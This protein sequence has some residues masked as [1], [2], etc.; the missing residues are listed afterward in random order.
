MRLDHLL[1]MEKHQFMVESFLKDSHGLNVDSLSFF[2][3][4]KYN[5]FLVR[6]RAISSVG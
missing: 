3:T 1:S 2:R 4:S 5:I 6:A